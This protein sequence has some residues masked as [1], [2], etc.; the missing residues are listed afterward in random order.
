MVSKLLL[1]TDEE[2]LGNDKPVNK[3]TPVVSVS[4][5]TY[6]HEAFIGQCLDGILM[7]QTSFPYEVIVGEDDS[8]DKTRD[9][10][11]KYA[12]QYPDKIRLFLRNKKDKIL[13]NGRH[14]GKTNSVK[15]YTAARGNYI[16]ICDGDDYWTDPSKLEKQVN[17]L[18]SHPE[19]VLTFHNARIVDE[20]DHFL[21]EGGVPDK[22]KKE[23]RG[24]DIIAGK[25]LP[26]LTV[27]FRN[28]SFEIPK[29]Y[30]EVLNGD[31]FLYTLLGHF[32]GAKY[33]EEISPAH[34]RKHSGGIWSALTPKE[35]YE[36]RINTRIKVLNVVDKKYRWVIRQ[37]LFED[38]LYLT[39]CTG[40]L[41][42]KVK[43]YFSA[44]RYFIFRPSFLS[45]Y[46]EVHGAILR[47][48]FN[49]KRFSGEGY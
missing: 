19:Y 25:W 30:F 45:K 12:E 15:N 23:G 32:G 41:F 46:L 5:T 11:K 10:C 29:E 14:T 20:N 18:E 7:Q 37:L 43:Q 13:V 44:Y 16:A 9:I 31:A 17:F 3:I 42:P 28:G 36:E 40:G 26:T 4:V 27:V 24:I 47:K 8:T 34:Y 48:L 21:S 49:I 39:S 1:P 38:S 35:R 6:N 33:I 22:L 2:Y